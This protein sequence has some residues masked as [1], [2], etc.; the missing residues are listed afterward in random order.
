MQLDL[1]SPTNMNPHKNIMFPDCFRDYKQYSEWLYVARIVKET[2]T[3]CED[4]NAEYRSKMVA[5]SRCH[6]EWT[7]IN[8]IVGRK[9]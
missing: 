9:G 6:K 3:I 1:F 8:W 7:E 5:Q 4:C 2:A